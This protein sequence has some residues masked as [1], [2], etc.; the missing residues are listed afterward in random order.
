MTTYQRERAQDLW[1]EIMPLLL[2]HKEEIAHYPDIA[3]EPDI[4][5]YNGIE[6]SGLLRCYTARRVERLIGYAVYFVRTSLHAQDSL[7]ALMD[8]LYVRP[9]ARR[10][11]VG[12]GLIQFCE[13][14]LKAEGVQV[15]F[16]HLHVSHPETIALFE[17]LGYERVDVILGKR[18][19]R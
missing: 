6:D 5:A 3:L 13:A 11:G 7:Q 14:A 12:V 19:D 1:P 17:R 18:L 10:G 8:V 9:D 15:I 4:Q 2:A 16:P